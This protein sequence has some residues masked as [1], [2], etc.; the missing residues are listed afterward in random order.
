MKALYNCSRV[1]Y[2]VIQARHS[3]GAIERFVIAY[4]DGRVLREFLARSAIVATG[5]SSRDEA[6]SNSLRVGSDAWRR[7][8]SSVDGIIVRPGF[9]LLRILKTPALSRL[10]G[11]VTWLTTDLLHVGHVALHKLQ[12]HCMHALRRLEPVVQ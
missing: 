6:M 10:K 2:A 11:R 8:L 1:Q 3:D 5:F 4:Q 12:F 9:A 7:V